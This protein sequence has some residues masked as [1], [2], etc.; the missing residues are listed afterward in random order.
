MSDEKRA[1]GTNRLHERATEEIR[2]LLARRKMSAA[3]LARRTGQRPA[4]LSRRMTGEIAF[5]LDD[6]EVIARELGVRVIDL[7][8]GSVQH[9]VPKDSGADSASAGRLKVRPAVP[10][11]IPSMRRPVRVEMDAAPAD[12][13]FGS[14][15][16]V[17]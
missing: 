4:A 8:G 5:D 16:L 12:Q 7:L 3:E 17:A 6:L 11:L 14:H 15:D 9:T 10:A 2:V 1:A 13:S